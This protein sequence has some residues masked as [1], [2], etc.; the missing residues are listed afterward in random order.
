MNSMREHR[1]SRRPGAG[2]LRPHDKIDAL[3]A[4]LAALGPLAADESWPDDPL[5]CN[6]AEIG[7]FIT[8]V[9]RLEHVSGRITTGWRPNCA[10]S[11]V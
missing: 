3:L 5:A 8:D 1:I 11:R 9:T 10:V 6:L 4:E 2:T 7:R